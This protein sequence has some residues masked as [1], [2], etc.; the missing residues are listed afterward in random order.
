MKYH[1]AQEEWWATSGGEEHAGGHF[2]SAAQV[3]EQYIRL[4][5]IRQTELLPQLVGRVEG[6]VREIGCG[7]GDQ[8]Q[9]LHDAGYK[10]LGGVEISA[11]AVKDANQGR[12]WLKIVC[13]SAYALPYEDQSVD[14]VY[15][16]GV[17]IHQPPEDVHEV[18]RELL[19]VVKPEG[20]I[21][22]VE[23]WAPEFQVRIA[24]RTWSGPYSDLY[25]ELGWRVVTANKYP[26]DSVVVYHFALENRGS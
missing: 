14:V 6:S 11:A 2:R 20:R 24:G 22:G 1:N 17:L 15:T 4:F 13:G 9:I 3:E 8:L 19:R 26:M 12:P 23:Y 16:C 18:A 10:D 25:Q 5:G 7:R 21:C